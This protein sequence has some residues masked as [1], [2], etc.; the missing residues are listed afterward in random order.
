[1]GPELWVGSRLVYLGDSMRQTPPKQSPT[2]RGF[3]EWFQNATQEQKERVVPSKRQTRNHVE[4]RKGHRLESPRM[5]AVKGFTPNSVRAT[6]QSPEALQAAWDRVP[7]MPPSRLNWTEGQDGLTRN[8]GPSD[9]GQC[10]HGKPTIGRSH[11]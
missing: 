1:M 4:R 2:E 7:G 6:Y 3:L 5:R 11:M 9:L 10:S 8:V